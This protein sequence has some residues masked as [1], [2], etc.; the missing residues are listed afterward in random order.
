MHE[1][2]YDMA[3][4][5]AVLAGLRAV[6]KAGLSLNVD[7]V[8]PL[9]DNAVGAGAY[10]PGEIID[11]HAGLRVYVENTDAE[12][13][14][15]LAD[16]MS[17]IID[18][19]DPR[20]IIDLATL[21]AGAHAS[22]G[23]AYAPLYCNAQSLRENL[24]A[25]GSRTGER[26]WPMPVHEIHGRELRHP[27]ADLKNLG[28]GTTTAC[29]AAAFLRRFVDDRPWAHIDLGGKA[30]IHYDDDYRV[31]GGTGWGAR[32]LFDYARR[33]EAQIAKELAQ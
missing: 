7:A 6:A 12:G 24:A 4:A 33:R 17:W 16:A 26:L 23:D 32:L 29:E 20:E 14:L 2:S 3:G 9:A 1:L 27:R 28:A 5:A 30:H 31:A 8:C 18:E 15:V 10:R 22:L 25:A 21:T 19:R 11:S 13:R